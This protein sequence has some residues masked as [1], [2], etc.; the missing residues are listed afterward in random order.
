MQAILMMKRRFKRR[1][2][3]TTYSNGFTG[4]KAI[5]FHISI[6]SIIVS[7]DPRNDF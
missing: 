4:R 3:N 7:G 6:R 1:T 2:D 5:F